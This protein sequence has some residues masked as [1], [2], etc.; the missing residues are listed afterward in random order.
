MT[1]LLVKAI[2]LEKEEENELN[3]L[4]CKWN[5]RRRKQQKNKLSYFTQV[6]RRKRYNHEMYQRLHRKKS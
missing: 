2:G 4:I 3:N 6:D 1:I 5:R